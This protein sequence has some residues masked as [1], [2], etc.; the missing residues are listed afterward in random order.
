MGYSIVV[1]KDKLGKISVE[2]DRSHPVNKGMLCSKGMNLH[3]TVNNDTDRLLYP[4]IRYNRNQPRQRVSWD[5]AL[6]RTAAAF[7]ALIEKMD[8]IPLLFMRRGNV[9]PEEYYVINKL[10]KGYIGSNNIDT[11]SRLC[12]SSAV[13]AYKMSLNEDCVPVNYDD[14]ELADVLFVAGANPAWCHPILWR[15]VEAARE[16]ILT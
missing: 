6:E 2:G 9:L 1:H 3:H 15:R 16:K 8:L 5:K 13:V 4:E 10:I 7:K 11:N 14:I 12:M